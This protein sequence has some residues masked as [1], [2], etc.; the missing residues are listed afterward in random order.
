VF[1]AVLRARDGFGTLAELKRKIGG[2]R[3]NSIFSA[4]VAARPAKSPRL[5]L[6]PQPQGDHLLDRRQVPTRPTHVIE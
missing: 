3:S 4:V 6:D 5:P 2:S 1:K